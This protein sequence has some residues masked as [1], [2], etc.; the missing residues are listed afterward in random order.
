MARQHPPS[1]RLLLVLVLIHGLMPAFGEAAEAVVHYATTGLLAHSEA[2]EGDL[3]DQG[4][5]HG[6]SPPTWATFGGVLSFTTTF[7]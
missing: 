1:I 2:G 3:G 5:A 7:N 6:C 4:G